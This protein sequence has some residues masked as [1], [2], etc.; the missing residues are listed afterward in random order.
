M[1]RIPEMWYGVRKADCGL[2]LELEFTHPPMGVLFQVRAG[3]CPLPVAA[4]PLR[5]S[6][7]IVLS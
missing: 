6:V 7:R 5:E 4:A 3:G 1:K 2:Y